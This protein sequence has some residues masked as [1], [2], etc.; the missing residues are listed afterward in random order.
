MVLPYAA[1]EAKI[2]M[3]LGRCKYL[4]ICKFNTQDACVANL[5]SFFV[6]LKL[7]TF[8]H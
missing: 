2:R 7:D 8:H 5:I 6:K 3:L 1:S 4:K